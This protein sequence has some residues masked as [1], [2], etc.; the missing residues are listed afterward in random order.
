MNN[1]LTKTVH[2]LVCEHL[3]FVYITT[4]LS[5]TVHSFVPRPSLSPIFDDLQYAGSES[6]E[7]LGSRLQSPDKH[8][9][10][11]LVGKLNIIPSSISSAPLSEFNCSTELLLRVGLIRT[12]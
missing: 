5:H 9:V 6:R 10:T 12:S 4:F 7:G 3:N 2:E 1:L 8:H 11:V